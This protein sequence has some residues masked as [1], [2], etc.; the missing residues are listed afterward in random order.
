MFARTA[1]GYQPQNDVEGIARLCTR[2]GMM[3]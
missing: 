2:G 1:I 3:G